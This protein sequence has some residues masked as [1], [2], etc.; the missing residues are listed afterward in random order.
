MFVDI[1]LLATT[2]ICVFT[3]LTKRK[4]YN[5][6]LFPAVTM[7][8]GYHLYTGGLSGGYFSLKGFCLGL[9]LLLIPYLLGGIGA[10]DVKFLAAIGALKGPCFIFVTFQAG[11]IAGGVLAIF[12]LLKNRKLS[13]TIRKILFPLFKKY[14]YVQ[15]SPANSAGGQSCS[16]PYGAAIAM[17]SVV[18]YFAR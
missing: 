11:A 3:D 18:A 16:I 1:L 5:L 12:Y 4:I 15:S 17:G 7:G 6:V 8:A 10:G 2:V 14:G 13:Y 9:A